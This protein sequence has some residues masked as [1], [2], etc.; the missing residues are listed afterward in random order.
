MNRSKNADVPRVAYLAAG[1]VAAAV[2]LHGM[3]LPA[4]KQDQ[5]AEVN[6]FMAILDVDKDHDGI[7]DGVFD[8]RIDEPR[9]KMPRSR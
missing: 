6:R 2:L 8:K 1:I 4:I 3:L 5:L 7:P 9:G